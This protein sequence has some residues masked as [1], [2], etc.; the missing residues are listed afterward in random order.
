MGIKIGMVG[1]GAFAQ[2]FIP[3]FKAHPLVDEVT[4]CDLDADKLRA[5]AERHG[6]PRTCPSLD[7]LL[8]TDVD[9]VAIITQPWLHAAQAIQALQAG[10]H[11]YSAVPTG[12]TVEEVA[13]LVSTVAQTGRIYMLGETSYYYPGVL[14]CREQHQGGAFGHIVYA[15]AEYYHDFDHGLYEVSRWRGGERWLETAG[16]PPMH[17]PTHST[18]QVI[19]VT[20]AHM[21]RVS[22]Q[23]FVDR[24]SDGIFRAEA[25]RWGNVFSDESA[26]F[27]MS[28]GSICRINEFRRIGH[29]GT[30]RMCLFGTEGSFE[31]NVAGA[32]WVSKD[33]TRN[34]RLDTLLACEGVPAHKLGAREAMDVVTSQ[35]GTHLGVSSVHPVERLPKEFIGLPNGHNGSHQFLVDDFVR[36]CVT[37]QTPPN[38]VWQ[39][40]R[41]ALPGIVAHESAVQGGILLDIPD[42]GDAPSS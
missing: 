12:I 35:D 11:V 20:G 1:T 18:G 40:A 14:Y 32:I 39:A 23:G 6:I 8:K 21:T 38:N 17:Y 27:S 24:S 13:N 4:L 15:E 34:V 3:L 37:Q 22:C 42:F 26:L 25:N 9:A 28:D 5:N 16:S 33:R 19:S 10:K 31:E 29:N 7:E 41:Y 36:A 30:V 2:S